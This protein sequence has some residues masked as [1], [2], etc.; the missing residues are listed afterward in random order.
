M[1]KKNKKNKIF[2]RIRHILSLITGL[3]VGFIFPNFIITQLSYLVGILAGKGI[4]SF[5]TGFAI[6]TFLGSQAGIW[7]QKGII[8]ILSYLTTNITLLLGEKITK[9]FKKDKTNLN[10]TKDIEI[11][12][13]IDKTDSIELKKENANEKNI[14]PK[15]SKEMLI[16]ELE[17]LKEELTSDEEKIK[18]KT[19]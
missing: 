8:A 3:V 9:A 18:M 1:K 19:K 5:A 10:E 4:I 14:K 12:K 13:D 15:K 11:T 16:R 17:L 6:T 2:S 7:L